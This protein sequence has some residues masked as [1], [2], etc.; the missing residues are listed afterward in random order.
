MPWFQDFIIN[1][2]TVIIPVE[3]TEEGH[4]YYE[5]MYFDMEGNRKGVSDCRNMT[6]SAFFESEGNVYA[7]MSN[8]EKSSGISFFII[9]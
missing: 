5:I 9:W 1:D 4:G 2:D 3:Y 8:D 7:V 6:V